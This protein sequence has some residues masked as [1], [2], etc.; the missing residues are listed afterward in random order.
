LLEA[1]QRAADAHRQRSSA[2]TRRQ[3]KG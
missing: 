1:T 2:P 3:R